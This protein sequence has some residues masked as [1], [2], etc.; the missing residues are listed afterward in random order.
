MQLK[1]Y[2]KTLHRRKLRPLSMCVRVWELFILYAYNVVTVCIVAAGYCTG[3]HPQHQI[4]INVQ[5]YSEIEMSESV[6]NMNFSLETQ[7]ETQKG[8]DMYIYWIY[9][10]VVTT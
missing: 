3:H 9:S 2:L 5:R 4:Y 1:L 7:I 10:Y 6:S 8:E